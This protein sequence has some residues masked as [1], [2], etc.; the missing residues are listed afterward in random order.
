MT[1]LPSEGNLL[2]ISAEHF[3][4]FLDVEVETSPRQ[5]G[6]HSPSQL[7]R[8]SA[9]LPTLICS[10]ISFPCLFLSQIVPAESRKVHTA[11]ELKPQSRK[12][13]WRIL[14]CSKSQLHPC[15]PPLCTR[16]PW[17]RAGTESAGSSWPS[18]NC[19]VACYQFQGG[20]I[21][22]SFTTPVSAL[23]SSRG[24]QPVL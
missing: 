4:L 17:N 22:L 9:S 21:M 7:K 19:C 20:K 12:M 11:D 16:W 6:Y 10:C 3:L 2:R 5:F 8:D 13:R 24:F 18:R 1:F 14:L 23:P 15:S